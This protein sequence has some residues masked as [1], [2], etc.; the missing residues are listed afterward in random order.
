MGHPTKTIHL[1]GT[2]WVERTSHGL[3]IYHPNVPFAHASMFIEN[4]APRLVICKDAP[5]PFR[6]EV[7]KHLDK[8]KTILILGG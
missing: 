7:Q 8:L 2:M 5:R 4:S 1:S 6:I 3:S